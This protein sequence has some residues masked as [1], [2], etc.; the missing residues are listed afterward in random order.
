MLKLKYKQLI[1][2]HKFMVKIEPKT[3]KMFTTTEEE[4]IEKMVN[5]NHTFRKLSMDTLQ[6]S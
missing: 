5:K 6:N 2:K 1:I 4:L 3:I